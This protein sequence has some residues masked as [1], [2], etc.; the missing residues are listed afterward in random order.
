MAKYMVAIL[1]RCRLLQ[2]VVGSPRQP[3]HG[4]LATVTVL[5]VYL[6]IRD[7]T[8]PA[9]ICLAGAIRNPQDSAPC[10]FPPAP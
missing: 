4:L 5:E 10:I 6:L 8:E 9:S 2:A 3:K 1:A 7:D